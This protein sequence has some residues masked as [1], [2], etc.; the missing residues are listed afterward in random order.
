MGEVRDLCREVCQRE[1]DAEY[2]DQ[3][4]VG[5]R[6]NQQGGNSHFVSNRASLSYVNK[7]SPHQILTHILDWTIVPPFLMIYFSTSA[8]TLKKIVI[9]IMLNL[10][11]NTFL[12]FYILCISS[13]SAKNW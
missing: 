9:F 8:H 2:C 10:L 7:F 5:D 4:G 13:K 3:G 11:T 12:K 6:I 1:A